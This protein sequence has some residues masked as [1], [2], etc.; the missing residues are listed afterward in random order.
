MVKKRKNR[1]WKYKA[2]YAVLLAV[3]FVL[4]VYILHPSPF[5]EILANIS[6][7]ELSTAGFTEVNLSV[8]IKDD[9]GIVFLGNDCYMITA[10][11][12]KSQ[13]VSIQNGIDKKVGPRPNAHD[14]FNDLLKNLN[15]KILM[16]KITKIENNAYHS[17]FILRQGNTLLNLDAR[18]SDAI[19]IA[20]RT[21]YLV[22]IY[23]NETLLKT[24]GK[25][26][27]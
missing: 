5:V 10:E 8:Q 6:L 20:A 27:C 9:Y 17:Q 26:I 1:F 25:K 14:L 3:I 18:P 12:E 7:P 21:D 22:P 19:A 4:L 11:V 13:A 23:V 16:I 15:I 24:V 2:S